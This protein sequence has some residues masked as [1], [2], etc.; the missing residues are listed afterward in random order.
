MSVFVLP[1]LLLSSLANAVSRNSGTLPLPDLRNRVGGEVRDLFRPRNLQKTQTYLEILEE[2]NRRASYP[3]FQTKS[4]SSLRSDGNTDL[5]PGKCLPK[6]VSLDLNGTQTPENFVMV[7]LLD[8]NGVNYVTPVKAQMGGTCQNYSATANV[9]I[10]LAKRLQSKIKKLPSYS[11][12]AF[13][14]INLSEIYNERLNTNQ[15]LGRL[16]YGGATYG[17]SLESMIP[18]GVD[19]ARSE[20][21]TASDPTEYN[22]GLIAYSKTLG[23]KTFSCSNP[24]TLAGADAQDFKPATACVKD[25]ASSRDDLLV[26]IGGTSAINTSYCRKKSDGTAVKCPNTEF[27]ATDNATQIDYRA[28]DEQ[29]KSALAATKAV[30]VSGAWVWN[31]DR[32]VTDVKLPGVNYEFARVYPADPKEF[33]LTASEIQGKDF[34]GE[35]PN[36]KDVQDKDGNV[37][38]FGFSNSHSFLIIG[39]LESAKTKK[40]YWIL[41]NSHGDSAGKTDL[42]FAPDRFLIMDAAGNT[43]SPFD[44][45]STQ[46]VFSIRVYDAQGFTAAEKSS[47]PYEVFGDEMT[48][49]STL[50]LSSP[51]KIKRDSKSGFEKDSDTDG[52][53]DLLDNCPYTANA[54]QE[55]QDTDRVGDV[56]DACAQQYDRYQRNS[57]AEYPLNDLDGNGIPIACDAFHGRIMARLDSD[58]PAYQPP[59]TVIN[60][61]VPWG[62]PLT[63]DGL[64][65][66]SK[67]TTPVVFLP[68]T[69]VTMMNLTPA[70]RPSPGVDPGNSRVVYRGPN[71]LIGI[72]RMSG[73]AL[74]IGATF[75]ESQP[76]PTNNPKYQKK[77]F[78]WIWSPSD[79]VLAFGP[80]LGGE[81][82]SIAMEDKTW[83]PTYSQGL[84][85]GK[86]GLGIFVWINVMPKAY[87]PSLAGNPSLFKDQKFF[88]PVIFPNRS[89]F[90]SQGRSVAPWKL[91]EEDRIIA[92]A[93]LN[94]DEYLDI[95]IQNADS[96]GVLG[97]DPGTQQFVTRSNQKILPSGHPMGASNFRPQAGLWIEGYKSQLLFGIN[98]EGGAMILDYAPGA[99]FSMVASF[100]ILDGAPIGTQKLPAAFNFLDAGVL[101]PAG[102]A[103]FDLDGAT[104]IVFKFATGV[105]ILSPAK[106][107]Q[108]N[109]PGLPSGG[110]LL[111][112]AQ[113]EF[114]GFSLNMTDFVGGV[115]LSGGSPVFTL[116]NA[117]TGAVAVVGLDSQG[118]YKLV[119]KFTAMGAVP[120]QGMNIQGLISAQSG[121]LLLISE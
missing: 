24:I 96:L 111:K 64:T 78:D 58:E 112:G 50:G 15:K 74:E 2:Q 70:T 71:G 27:G 30:R 56:C 75:S 17:I 35:K 101:G 52:I 95:I 103:D 83:T 60:S 107:L 12:A 106:A 65:F 68:E 88:I 47:R 39:Y 22:Q 118:N 11:P 26:F 91:R 119:R 93:E 67:A 110:L 43:T 48:F 4:G 116:Q 117:T 97:F 53:I 44:A 80:F 109:G 32:T 5:T 90:I 98:H 114:L 21:E 100:D 34:K 59:K 66:G 33:L 49:G 82:S 29:I 20:Q 92:V 84:L 28:S 6:I 8:C 102:Y 31:G 1:A 89:I 86:S 37:Y 55:D 18:T 105:G 73:Q 41:K 72:G 104:D 57:L 46:R 121:K 38:K 36:W 9:E 16:P 81:F 54:G 113:S 19:R 62:T 45:D 85:R 61:Q 7:S 10:E 79:R 23:K 51:E 99:G 13:P 69:Q 14:N 87:P 40:N 108:G 94:G 115:T 120:T 76:F 42:A 63:A 25:F 3:I 77:F